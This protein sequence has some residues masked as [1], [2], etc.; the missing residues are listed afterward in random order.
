M[1]AHGMRGLLIPLD[2]NGSISR[3]G[4]QSVWPI[5][6][7][8][9]C[10][11][12][13]TNFDKTSLAQWG[14]GGRVET[15]SS[16]GHVQAFSETLLVAT[17]ASSQSESLNDC[18]TGVTRRKKFGDAQGN[19]VVS[20]ASAVPFQKVPLQT[21]PREQAQ[22]ANANSASS[23]ISFVGVV[24]PLDPSIAITGQISSVRQNIAQSVNGLSQPASMLSGAGNQF[25]NMRIESLSH[26]G[27][28]ASSADVSEPQNRPSSIFPTTDPMVAINLDA[29]ATSTSAHRTSAASD[30]NSIPVGVLNVVSQMSASVAANLSTNATSLPAQ[31]AS[32]ATDQNSIPSA[33]SNATSVM[34]ANVT[35]STDTDAT[36]T[37]V[38]STSATTDQNSIPA[39]VSDEVSEIPVKVVASTDTDVTS[40]PTQIT[41]AATDQSSIPAAVSDDVSEIAVKVA[42]STD[43]DPTS[44][45]AHNASAVADQS[46]IPTDVSNAASKMPTNVAA[47]PVLH[48]A[49]K[50]SIESVVAP[51]TTSKSTDETVPPATVSNQSVRAE[52]LG[53]FDSVASQLASM[54]QSGGVLPGTIKTDVSNLNA[55]SSTKLSPTTATNGKYTANEVEGVKQQTLA[56][57]DQTGSQAGSQSAPTSGDQNQDVATSRG[58]SM[59]AVQTNIATHT[60]L[61]MDPVQSA[62]VASPALSA[63]TRAG[64]NGSSMKAPDSA[65][66]V[67]TAAEQ[68][69]PVINSAKLIQSM[70]Q[71]EMRVGMRSNEFGNISIN[72]S[73][74]RDSISAQISVDHGELAKELA[75]HLPEM[76]ARLSG[77]QA[78]NVRIDMNGGM[79]GQGTGTSGGMS[80]GSSDQSRGGRQQ[81]GSAASNY[82]TSSAVERQMS[83]AASTATTGY[84]SLNARLDI[85]V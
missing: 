38:Q 46:S 79:H 36:S 71:T 14:T 23:Q 50:A 27:N 10:V 78:V 25:T 24:A 4:A 75:A 74:T 15:Q 43:T 59:A 56:P 48:A 40:S 16:D 60:V 17:K 80:Y 39:A 52:G 64:I 31:S 28:S 68:A 11:I 35:T 6:C 20:D 81:S 41:S 63:P 73:T 22:V 32:A 55:V 58:A 12:A 57:S 77:D 45:P 65:A 26:K 76:Q 33:V 9:V 62:A 8:R 3:R 29:N 82:A 21:A 54:N 7:H 69:P 19:V 1:H 85:R 47:V 70:G 37:P 67:S 13:A 34:P 53:L 51:A 49:L 83:S 72:T 2:I 42:A 84:G 18:S 61:A 66:S 5:K 30:Q 44:T